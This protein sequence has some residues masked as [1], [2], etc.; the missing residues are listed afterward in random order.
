MCTF[1]RLKYYIIVLLYICRVSLDDCKAIGAIK[2]IRIATNVAEC[3]QRNTGVIVEFASKF[4]TACVNGEVYQS[5]SYTRITTR[6]SYTVCY[7]QRT[8]ERYGL[9]EY[10]LS[11]QQ[12]I[13]AVISPLVQLS[14]P[15]Y[16]AV[17][18]IL[19][20]RIIPVMSGRSL[21]VISVSL[22]ISKT[23]LISLDSDKMYVCKFP[24]KFHD[25]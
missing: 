25:D 1:T 15:C 18:S 10:F 11:F 19:N 6:N 22:L 21:D 13:L 4:C 16:P 24:N 2:T 5:K 17:L 8:E 7:T 3:I 23:I 14:T 12:Q 9:I 20:S